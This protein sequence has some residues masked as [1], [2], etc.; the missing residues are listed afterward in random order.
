MFFRK[1]TFE[2]GCHFSELRNLT[3]R[4]CYFSFFGVLVFYRGCFFGEFWF[5]G[6]L[7]ERCLSELF[8]PGCDPNVAC[9]FFLLGSGRW[10]GVAVCVVSLRVRVIGPL[11]TC[12]ARSGALVR[13]RHGHG[14]A[15]CT[16]KGGRCISCTIV[17][18]PCAVRCARAVRTPTDAWWQHASPRTYL[19]GAQPLSGFYKTNSLGYFTLFRKMATVGISQPEGQ[20][21]LFLRSIQETG[22]SFQ[23]VFLALNQTSGDMGKIDL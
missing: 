4:D 17:H 3:L 1:A 2:S 5:S 8:L 21:E 14:T 13:R 22:S 6:G 20:A 9:R 16:S 18:E 19:G 12:R 15:S 23:K 7:S 10:V 11:A